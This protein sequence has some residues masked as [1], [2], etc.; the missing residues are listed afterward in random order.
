MDQQSRVA[1]SSRDRP[2]GRQVGDG[3]ADI[4]AAE[5]V[6]FSGRQCRSASDLEVVPDVDDPDGHLRGVDDCVVFGPGVDMAGQRDDVVLGV[7]AHVAA[8]GDQRR[9]V[10]GLPDVQVDVNRVGS[11]GDID[12]VADVADTGRRPRPPRQRRAQCRRTRSWSG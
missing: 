6:E 10:Q 4:T 12:V 1:D 9:A 7:R 2:S 5:T 3:H 8:V 11:V